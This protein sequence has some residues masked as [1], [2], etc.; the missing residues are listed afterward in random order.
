MEGLD[1]KGDGQGGLVHELTAALEIL[2]YFEPLG[3]ILHGASHEIHRRRR[4]GTE[5]GGGKQFSL[6]LG[7]VPCQGFKCFG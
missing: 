6:G 4:V 7:E 3:Q 1:G 5:L 2:E